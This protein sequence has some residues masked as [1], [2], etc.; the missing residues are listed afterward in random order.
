MVDLYFF[1]DVVNAIQGEKPQ[2]KR[3]KKQLVKAVSLSQGIRSSQSVGEG[4]RVPNVE[5][6]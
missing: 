3:N 5:A 6:I 1:D 4:N 2:K